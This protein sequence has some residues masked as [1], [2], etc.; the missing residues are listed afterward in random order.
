MSMFVDQILKDIQLKPE[1]WQLVNGGLK[2]RVRDIYIIKFGNGH[3]LFGFWCTSIVE[4]II[5]GESVRLTWR[6]QFRLEQAFRR[7]QSNAS[8]EMLIA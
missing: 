5:K 2:Y 6:D 1:E 3:L 7:W 8:L 4:V